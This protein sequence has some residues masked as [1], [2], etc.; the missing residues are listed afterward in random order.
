MAKVGKS[1]VAASEVVNLED[2]RGHMAKVG[3]SEVTVSEVVKLEAKR[4]HVAHMQTC[5][6]EGGSVGDLE[7]DRAIGLVD[8]IVSEMGFS[9][10]LGREDNSATMG[11]FVGISC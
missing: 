3:E 8:P 1:E 2:R 9:M 5:G 6:G 11:G 10:Q 7:V 4:G